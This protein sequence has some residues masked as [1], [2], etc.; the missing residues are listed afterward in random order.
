MFDEPKRSGLTHHRG[1]RLG[2]LCCFRG[3]G[4]TA[5]AGLAIVGF[6]GAA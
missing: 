4:C 6:P 5:G 1:R 2:F 3:T